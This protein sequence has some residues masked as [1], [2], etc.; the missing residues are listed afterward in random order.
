MSQ[1]R[2]WSTLVPMDK[3][4]LPLRRSLP[5]WVKG[6]Y[7]SLTQTP[8]LQARSLATNCQG[9]DEDVWHP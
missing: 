2:M 3:Y 5:F 4:T 1:W 8:S 9:I 6:V 7:T